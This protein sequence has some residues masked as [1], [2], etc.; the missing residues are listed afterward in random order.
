MELQPVS[1]SLSPLMARHMKKGRRFGLS[2]KSLQG[3]D[4]T[5]MVHPALKTQ[6]EKARSS[7]K[8]KRLSLS[9]EEI[10]A[11]M[12]K[13]GGRI[14]FIGNTTS[15]TGIRTTLPPKTGGKNIGRAIKR[16]IRKI[17]EDYKEF[18]DDPKNAKTRKV[19]Q[20][21]AKKGITTALTAAATAAGSAMGAPGAGVVAAPIA[22]EIAN[23]AVEKIGLGMR[24]D[25][26][27]H[28]M[29]ASNNHTFL[30]PM[31]PAMAPGDTRFRTM[32]GCGI[33]INP[34]GGYGI[35]A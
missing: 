13:M 17:K 25:Q 22:N 15:D 3:S 18:R 27:G 26:S 33:Y 24:Y 11:S 10:K 32:S 20:E 30:S 4:H 14:K 2:A 23:V 9:E 12:E 19:I 1:V 31:H 6:I 8:G 16:G 34:K 5:L 28:G 35:F 29:L 7:G 21:V